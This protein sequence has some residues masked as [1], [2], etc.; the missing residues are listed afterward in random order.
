[1]MAY[2]T[3]MLCGEESPSRIGEKLQ[4]YA[5]WAESAESH[6]FLSTLYRH[7]GA[8]SPRPH[9]RL[10]VIAQNRR[11]G[12]DAVRLRQVLKATFD[13]PASLQ[14]RMWITTVSA[15]S[16]ADSI[17]G[18][19]WICGQDLT[20]GTGQWKALSCSKRTQF[21]HRLA[22]NLPRR[23]LFPSVDPKS[24]FSDYDTGSR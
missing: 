7:F 21:L 19:V 20:D 24:C 4:K 5:I 12:N 13:L 1:M 11:T 23:P 18:N 14:R 2:L 6:E 16:Q 10:V 8:K 3:E 15:L 17:N 22:N 9:F